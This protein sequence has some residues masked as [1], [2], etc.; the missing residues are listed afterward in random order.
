VTKR[1]TLADPRRFDLASFAELL[2]ARDPIA[3]EDPGSFAGFHAGMMASLAPVTPYECTL[4][5]NLIAIE[6]ERL[7]HRRMRDASLRNAIREAICAAFLAKHG[8]ILMGE[9]EEDLQMH[10]ESGGKDEDWSEPFE[11]DEDA[12]RE[13]GEA[14]AQKAMSPDAAQQTVA[15]DE[16]T[17]LGIAP[18]DLMGE[19]YRDARGDAM[20]HEPRIVDLEKR[21]R[22]VR[23]DFETLQKAQ[24]FEAR[25]VRE[26]VVDADVVDP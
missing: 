15:W 17:K 5:E 12:L 4:A 16:M 24:P 6:W 21:A 8:A 3:G 1:T 19:A 14:L 20:R 9:L 26:D 2:P 22:E 11:I 7:Q 18:V 10:L 13:E 23:R 25:A